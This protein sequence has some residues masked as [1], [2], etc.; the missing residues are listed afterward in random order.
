MVGEEEVVS[1]FCVVF[2][3]VFGVE[4]TFWFWCRVS[5]GRRLVGGKHRTFL[6][7]LLIG[8]V[9][10]GE[11]RRKERM[12]C[13]PDQGR[14]DQ[15]TQAIPHSRL[16]SDP[17]LFPSSLLLFSFHIAREGNEDEGLMMVGVILIN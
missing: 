5:G 8:F 4:D 17:L 9:G 10:I 6:V 1:C 14:R 2:C 13:D 3:V 11:R 15:T 12:R 16:S 7:V